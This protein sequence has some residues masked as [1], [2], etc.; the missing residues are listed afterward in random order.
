MIKEV[1]YTTSAHTVVDA[2]YTAAHENLAVGFYSVPWSSDT[3][4]E[5]F[6]MFKTYII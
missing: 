1:K 6:Q 4:F 3:D 2:L 5:T